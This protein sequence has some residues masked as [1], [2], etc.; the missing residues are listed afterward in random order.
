MQPGA[1]LADAP[2]QHQGHDSW[3]LQHLGGSFQLLCFAPTVDSLGAEQRALIEQ[4]AQR[5]AG[6]IPVPTLLVTERDGPAPP[7]AQVLV[8]TRRRVAQRL[9]ASP[10]S[11]Y[12]LRPDQHVAARWRLPTGADVCAALAR[13]SAQSAQ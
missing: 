1:P 7:G 5:Q 6:R 13:A 4:L 8:D 10:G 12:L 11:A 2:V 3:L 9:D